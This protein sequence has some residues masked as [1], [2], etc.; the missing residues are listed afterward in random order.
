MT[1][2]RWLAMFA[3]AW[4][5]FGL[6]AAIARP[7]QVKVDPRLAFVILGLALVW[8]LFGVKCLFLLKPSTSM[9][10]TRS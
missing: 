9:L 10:A 6:L 8:S 7:L 2:R 4:L 5:L 3:G 1:R